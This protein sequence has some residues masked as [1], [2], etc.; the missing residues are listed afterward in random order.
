MAKADACG[1]IFSRRS[2][3]GMAAG[4][5]AAAALG[6]A[7]CAGGGG[8]DGSADADDEWDGVTFET[9]QQERDLW[10]SAEACE[11][12]VGLVMGPPSMGLSQFM[13]AAQNGLTENDFAFTVVGMDYVTAVA[14]FN[15]GDYDIC[16]LPSNIGPILYNN[17][18]LKSDYRVINITNLGVLYVLTTD[19]D[20][21]ELSDLAG[22]TVYS[23]GESGTPEY[24]T[25][26]L[27]KKLGLDGTFNLEF[28][29]SPLE[30]VNMLQEVDGCVAILPQPFVTLAQLL[31]DDLYV[32]I[33]LTTE[34]DAAFAD[35]GSQAVT[36]TTIV[37]LEFLEE[38]EQAVVEY[39][40]MAAESVAWTLENIEEA[41]ALQESLD[42]F[43]NNEVAQAAMPYLSLVCLTGEEMRTALAGFLRELYEA[44]PESIGGAMP[45]EDFYYLPP[46]G[47][48]DERYLQAGLEEALN[49]ASATEGDD[50]SATKEDAEAA[51]EAFA[52]S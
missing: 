24:T 15:S 49:R 7:G 37:R 20:L 8:D 14:Q 48:L 34:W 30:V 1:G 45:G 17:E 25:T 51:L 32:P 18:D 6:L 31:V 36:A 10:G 44:D 29:S 28:K 38:H 13:V 21:A 35:T 46:A 11:V 40:N 33:D 47:E 43:L 9:T 2:F 41:A 39:L 16:T 4:T 27:M 50:G 22:R 23:Y 3:M 5:A 19:P 26:A 12:R 42:T 52:A